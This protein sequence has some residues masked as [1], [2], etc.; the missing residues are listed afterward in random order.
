LTAHMDWWDKE[1][2]DAL[3]ERYQVLMF[4]AFLASSTALK[5]MTR[6]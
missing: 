5:L 2:I 1:L 3:A 6:P 4:P